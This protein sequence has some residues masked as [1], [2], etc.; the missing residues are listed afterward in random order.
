MSEEYDV[1]VVGGGNAGLCSSIVASRL[2]RKVLLIERG[3]EVSRGGNSKYTRDIRYAHDK[4][5][6]T[7]GMYT[8]EEFLNDLL[9]VTKGETNLSLAKLVIEKSYEIKEFMER[10]GIKWQK[11]LRGTLHL[12]RTNAFFL[13]GGKQL[14]NT[15]YKRVKENK[16]KV[17][18]NTTVN[19]LIISEDYSFSG[20]V[21]EEGKIIRGKA[22]IVSS[23]GFEANTSWLGQYYGEA[24][25]N[26]IIRGTKYN[27]GI[28]LRALLNKGALTAGDPKGVHAIAVDA[29]SPKF[30][31]GIVTRV[32][33]IP[34][35][36]VV[37]KRGKRFYDEGEDIW[38][39]RYAIWGKLIAEQEDQI[40]YSI[41][42][43]KAKDLFLP[44]I[45]Q[46]YKVEDMDEMEEVLNIEKGSLRKTIEEYNEKVNRE[47][48]FNPLDLDDC[49]TKGLEIPKSHW[50][51]PIDKPPFYVYP[52]RPGITFTYMGV[53]VNEEARVKERK[54]LFKNVFATGEIMSGN[55]L[56]RGYL[57]GFGLTIGTVFG[58]IAGERAVEFS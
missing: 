38:P 6:A 41:V 42:D 18:Y 25:K 54:G 32:D 24:V 44:T 12:S 16:V 46:P 43:S 55:I 4:D 22:L 53:E 3:D 8:K 13:G 39:K 15:Y 21:T 14:V 17:L 19:D 35:S 1:I 56:T 34:F 37:N 57:G 23:G 36:I 20:V 2:G 26:F 11:P 31:G 48:H 27:D 50:A 33:S 9:S 28:L 58:I 30:D 29:R 52:L 45:Y 51:L 47:C 40:V 7:T 10:N 5:D 49:S